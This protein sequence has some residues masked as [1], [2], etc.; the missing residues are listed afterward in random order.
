MSKFLLLFLL[1]FSVA[2]ASEYPQTFSKLGTP[3]YKSL[4][5]ISKYSEI[6]LLQEKILTYEQL[7]NKTIAHGFKVDKSKDKAE[8]KKYLFELRELQKSYDFLLHLLHDNINKAIDNKDYKLFLKLTNYEFDG[9]LKN[10]N[11][12]N[13]AMAFY[14]ENRAKKRS[15]VLEKKRK[16]AKLIKESTQEFYNQ[17]VQSTYDPNAKQDST[18]TVQ[19]EVNRVG[20]NIYVVFKNRNIFD[21]TVSI[22]SKYKNITETPNTPK[23]IVLK[24]QSSKNYTKLYLG[25]GERQ[26]SYSYSW[27]IGDKD[28]VHDD[29][30]IYRLPYKAG[31]THRVSQGYN[32]RA[33][34]KGSSQYSVDF[35]MD[36]GTKIYAARGGVVVKTKSDSNIGGYSKEFA[37]YGNYVTIAH[38]DGTLG[39]Y[40]HLKYGGV[41]VSVGDV[42]QRGYALGYSG[43][44]GYSSGPH[45]HFSVF[46][47]VSAQKTHTIPIRFSSKNGVIEEP[48]EGALYEAK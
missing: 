26:Y 19:I 1:L 20:E 44:T 7:V 41:L 14:S 35:A 31:T 34:H 8:I 11:L 40:Y 16:Y 22:K 28:A 10:S 27:I 5:P 2:F 30:Y 47:A 33:T 36:E 43:N 39:T 37:K 29:S 17:T 32:G 3:L 15:K 12:R 38:E 45:L 21:V 13:K 4:K 48:I 6:E 42:V 25:K 24:A 46:S 9:L 23:V 18:K